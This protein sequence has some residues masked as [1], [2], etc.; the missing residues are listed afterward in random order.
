MPISLSK[1]LIPPNSQTVCIDV[2]RTDIEYDEA[3]SE[4]RGYLKIEMGDPSLLPQD[5]DSL[6]HLLFFLIY[7]A[8]GR[9][10]LVDNNPLKLAPELARSRLKD[11]LHQRFPTLGADRLDI[12]IDAHFAADAWLA[13]H[14]ASDSAGQQQQ[15]ALYSQKLCAILGALHDDA[16]SHEFSMLW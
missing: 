8:D 11:A 14:G 1:K 7:T 6:L 3:L 9:Q 5:G 2:T 13:A 10:L 16:L 12:V 15:Q 4:R